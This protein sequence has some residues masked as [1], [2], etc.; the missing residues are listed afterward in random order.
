M[1][2]EIKDLFRSLTIGKEIP[3]IPKSCPDLPPLPDFET[4]LKRA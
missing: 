4:M 1:V 3:P 2:K